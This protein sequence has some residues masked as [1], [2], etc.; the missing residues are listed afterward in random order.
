MSGAK[1]HSQTL[2]IQS[3]E[4][5]QPPPELNLPDACPQ[6]GEAWVGFGTSP[7]KVSLFCDHNH[8]HY[9]DSTDAEVLA[10]ERALYPDKHLAR[11]VWLVGATEPW[12]RMPPLPPHAA[13]PGF[14]LS[15]NDQAFMVVSVES[16][17]V[18]LQAL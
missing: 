15:T 9:R 5:N 13:L 1:G 17:R 12:P 8:L 11:E 7:G 6:C 3:I 4:M 18:W 2:D 16:S 10:F 14:R